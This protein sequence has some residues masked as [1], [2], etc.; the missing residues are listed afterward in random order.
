[1]DELCLR[2]A[3]RCLPE[4]KRSLS[5]LVSVLNAV[6]DGMAS[7]PDDVLDFLMAGGTPLVL[8][9]VDTAPPLI[10]AKVKE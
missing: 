10:P 3:G 1:M 9:V 2:G 7:P 8:K 5:E 4:G 6:L